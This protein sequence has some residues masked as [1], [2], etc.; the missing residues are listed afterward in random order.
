M[1]F[2]EKLKKRFRSTHPRGAAKNSA[3][4][5]ALTSSSTRK[6]CSHTLRPASRSQ[7]NWAKQ[8]FVLPRPIDSFESNDW[9][10]PKQNRHRS[11]QL[12][13]FLPTYFNFSS[14]WT[15]SSYTCPFLRVNFQTLRLHVITLLPSN[16][17][18]FLPPFL[19]PAPR[20]PPFRTLL[21]LRLI[22]HYSFSTFRVSPIFCIF[23]VTPQFPS[24][25]SLFSSPQLFIA[26]L[27]L[28]LFLFFLTI[29][30]PLFSYHFFYIF[31]Y[32]I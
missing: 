14:L 22:P 13:F 8:F 11:F 15:V 3:A 31:S 17:L 16:H 4:P 2:A 18:T 27:S 7:Q 26:L 28:R 20:P 6:L 21:P 19:T 30:S 29:Q 32:L 1:S 5:H 23:S 24:L 12:Q 9:S 25:L 10:L